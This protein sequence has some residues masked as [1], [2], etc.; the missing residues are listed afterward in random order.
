MKE[1]IDDYIKKAL[2]SL[3]IT[4]IVGSINQILSKK[5]P[6]R[7]QPIVYTASKLVKDRPPE[8]YRDMQRIS[9]YGKPGGARQVFYE[10]AKF[11]ENF[12][13]DYTGF[14]EFSSFY[15]VYEYMTLK[16]KRSY[17]TWRTAVRDG[18]LKPSSISFGYLYIYELINGIGTSSPLDGFRKLKS[19]FDFFASFEPSAKLY[20][21]E[22][23]TDYAVYYCLE[24]SVLADIYNDE[25]YEAELALQNSENYTDSEL[26]AALCFYSSYKLEKSVYYRKNTALFEYVISNAYR[27]MRGSEK[28]FEY[29]K[30]FYGTALISEHIMFSSAV[31]YDHLPTD[32]RVYEVNRLLSFKKSGNRW[33][34]TRILNR[35]GKNRFIGEFIK[36]IDYILRTRDPAS[37]QLQRPPS[38]E[39]TDQAIFHV[40]ECF[41]KEQKKQKLDII[42]IDVSRLSEIKRCSLVTQ[43]KLIIDEEEL[44]DALPEEANASKAQVVDN[45]SEQ[46]CTDTAPTALSETETAFLRCLLSGKPYGDLLAESGMLL[47]VICDSVNEKLFESFGDTVID[48]SGDRPELIEDYISDL[49]GTVNYEDT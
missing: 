1:S 10:Q 27:Y 19:F 36:N 40:L 15:P 43:S 38:A 33:K 46:A 30:S 4:D 12:R 25:S 48:M 6:Y 31:F 34:R 49:K 7:D 9:S 39:H 32:D 42:N 26:F 18:V 22:W 8:E 47:S 29:V 16:Q 24:P 41:E 23:L 13:D 2:D 44:P 21:D 17:F 20:R 37:N 14:A 28:C 45:C 35:R 3:D 11:M 5:A